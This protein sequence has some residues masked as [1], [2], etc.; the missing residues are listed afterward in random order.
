[1]L[2]LLMPAHTW[3]TVNTLCFDRKVLLVGIA[4]GNDVIALAQSALIVAVYPSVT[5]SNLGADLTKIADTQA[6]LARR[7]LHRRVLMHAVPSILGITQYQAGQFDVAIYN[8]GTGGD[9]EPGATAAQIANYADKLIVV[10]ENIPEMWNAVVDTLPAG[11][12]TASSDG[13]AIFVTM[14]APVPTVRQD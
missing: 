5:A 12:F 1:M 4:D 6:M 13:H 2:P 8:P 14:G 7:G 3:D 9:P 10:G 11:S